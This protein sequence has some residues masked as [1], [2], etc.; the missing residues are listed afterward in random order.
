MRE[1][2]GVIPYYALAAGFLSWN[3]RSEADFGKSPLGPGMKKFLNARGERSLA[4]LDAAAKRLSATPAQIALAWRMMQPGVRAPIASAT[5]LAQLGELLA[6]T[7]LTLDRD[8]LQ[9]LDAASAP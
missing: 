1:N 4:S 2:I 8:A 7:R 5:S 9:A 3:F 6:A